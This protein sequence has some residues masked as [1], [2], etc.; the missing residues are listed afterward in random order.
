[1]R[2]SGEEHVLSKSSAKALRVRNAINA[3][4]LNKETRQLQKEKNSEERLFLKKRERILQRQSSL[5]GELTPKLRR[6]Q[7]DVNGKQRL[8]S[9]SSLRLSDQH[10]HP[11]GPR[12]RSRALSLTDSE[13]GESLPVSLPDIFATA[14]GKTGTKTPNSEA[15]LRWNG[16]KNG[17]AGEECEETCSIDYWKKLRDCRYLRTFSTEK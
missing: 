1:M 11:F 8:L 17:N 16:Y 4:T 6:K 10:E 14:K 2:P 9:A 7:I 12:F 3:A 5:V 15:K 13:V